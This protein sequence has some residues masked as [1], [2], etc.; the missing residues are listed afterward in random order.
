M[1]IF[2]LYDRA[3]VITR[4]GLLAISGPNTGNPI[5]G[6]STISNVTVPAM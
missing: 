5:D 4:I 2:S 1:N 3:G 6:E